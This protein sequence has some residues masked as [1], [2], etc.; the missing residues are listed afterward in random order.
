VERC[1]VAKAFTVHACAVR[2]SRTSVTHDDQ[3]RRTVDG[4][5]AAA[6]DRHRDGEVFT[7]FPANPGG[8]NSRRLLSANAVVSCAIAACN[9]KIIAHVGKPAII[10]AC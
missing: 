7:Q 3:D 6:T 10:A 8:R 5:F 9:S 2:V 4:L 1:D